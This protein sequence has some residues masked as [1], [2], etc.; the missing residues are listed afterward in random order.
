MTTTIWHLISLSYVLIYL[1][2]VCTVV[3]TCKSAVNRLSDQITIFSFW[4][5]VCLSQCSALQKFHR[6][7]YEPYSRGLWDQSA[8]FCQH[9][10]S[11]GNGLGRWVVHLV[12]LQFT[13]WPC[14]FVCL[15]THVPQRTAMALIEDQVQP[16]TPTPLLTLPSP[17][18]PHTSPPVL[19]VRQDQYSPSAVRINCGTR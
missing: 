9:V 10:L 16:W 19:D 15:C 3:S 5:F 1:F 7:V 17:S 6:N 11:W 14:V 12:H 4:H 13:G 2:L 18:L 8:W